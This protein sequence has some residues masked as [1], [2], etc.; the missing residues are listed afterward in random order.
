[1]KLRGEIV[2]GE[3]SSPDAQAAGAVSLFD[4][5]GR[6]RNL[7]ATERLVVTDVV[8]IADAKMAV[9]VFSDNDG[10]ST[11]DAGERIA[12]GVL[13]ANT[14]LAV[15]FATPRYCK[16]GVTPKVKAGAVG[17]VDVLLTGF[18]LTN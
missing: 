1:M 2:H 3:F 6:V 7:A 14:L 11:E 16:R 17:Q 8:V 9:D 15:S 12:G 5:D 4:G 13:A 10:D 18:I